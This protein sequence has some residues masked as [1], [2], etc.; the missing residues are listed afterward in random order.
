MCVGDG[1][2]R[3]VLLVRYL[4]YAVE[5]WSYVCAAAGG[6]LLHC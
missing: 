3:Y 5:C 6:M 2:C 1:G 4:Q